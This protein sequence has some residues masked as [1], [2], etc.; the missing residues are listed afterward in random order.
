MESSFQANTIL[1]ARKLRVLLINR[2]HFA[3]EVV[4]KQNSHSIHLYLVREQNF[5]QGASLI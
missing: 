4:G 3:I 5:S 1:G 2:L